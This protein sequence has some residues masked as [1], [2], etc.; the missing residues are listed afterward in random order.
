ML[1]VHTLQFFIHFVGLYRVLEQEIAFAAFMLQSS[2][3]KKKTNKLIGHYGTI[4]ED[5]Q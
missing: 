2:G 1:I 3:Q 4:L 5:L